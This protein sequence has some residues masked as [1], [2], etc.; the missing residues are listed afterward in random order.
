MERNTIKS[1]FTL[2][3]LMVVVTIVAMLMVFGMPAVR[4]MVNSFHCDGNTRA[5]INSAFACARSIAVREQS[6]A[7][8]RFQKAYNPSNPNNP[9]EWPQYMV[10]VIY[11]PCL[12]NVVQGNLGC[13][14]V[15]G[16][17]PIKLPEGVGVTDLMLGA[18]NPD[19]R[20]GSNG[21]LNDDSEVLDV[22]TFTM[23]FSPAGK[24]I[25]H[26]LWVV[27]RDQDTNPTTSEDD[28]FNTENNVKGG[29]GI[30]IQ[31]GQITGIQR[32][33]SRNSFVI[34]DSNI[35]KRTDVD[36]NKRWDDYLKDLPASHINSYT[37]AIINN[38]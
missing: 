18:S 2:I 21:D 32:E 6:Y 11:D 36:V 15:E 17:E 9:L 1:G 10:F 24:L 35:L 33:M 27:N 16:M 23:L 13:R 5:M 14:A 4:T 22:T 19:A 8:I 37:G 20:V 12:P 29:T 3:E 34:F 38:K 7:G 26:E 31:D 30:F 25:I 28:I